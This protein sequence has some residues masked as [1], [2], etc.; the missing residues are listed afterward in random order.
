[1]LRNNTL[2]LSQA[3]ILDLTMVSANANTSEAIANKLHQ[4]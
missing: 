3:D 4:I 1:M 2:F